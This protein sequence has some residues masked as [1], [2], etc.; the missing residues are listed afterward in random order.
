MRDYADGFG[1]LSQSAQH[2]QRKLCNAVA[3]AGITNIVAKMPGIFEN[4]PPVACIAV[5]RQ[6]RTEDNILDRL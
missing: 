4:A 6:G 5:S 1:T 3:T 2:N